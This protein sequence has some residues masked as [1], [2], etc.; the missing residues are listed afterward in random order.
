MSPISLL[1]TERPNAPN[2]ATMFE[3]FCA[4]P[5]PFCVMRSTQSCQHCKS[6]NHMPMH[7]VPRCMPMSCCNIPILRSSAITIH[8][9]HQASCASLFLPVQH[10]QHGI[11][12]SYIP[13]LDSCQS[14]PEAEAEAIKRVRLG[15]GTGQDDPYTVANVL[16]MQGSLH[17]AETQSSR[18]G[19]L[20][21]AASCT[22]LGQ[23]PNT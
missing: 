8:N 15:T 17:Q 6:T 22:E 18:Q 14:R 5:L 20:K 9:F 16:S 7:D 21:N 4:F 10:K 19:H 3:A 2:L 11:E 1:F 12:H 13:D 23:V